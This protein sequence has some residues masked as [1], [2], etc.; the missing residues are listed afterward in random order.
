MCE[1]PDPVVSML[2][3]LLKSIAQ[4]NSQEASRGIKVGAKRNRLCIRYTEF[5]RRVA[6]GLVVVCCCFF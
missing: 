1:E 4:R 6:V 2:Q 5:S 3:V